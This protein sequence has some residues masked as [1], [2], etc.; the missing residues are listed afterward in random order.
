MRPREGGPFRA[1]LTTFGRR[2]GRPHAVEL[3]AVLHGGRIYFS[4]RRPDSDWFRNAERNPRVL[5]DAPALRIGPGAEGTAAVVRDAGLA[6]AIS[7]LKYPG[8][9][10][11]AE[12]RVA[13]GVALRGA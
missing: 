11:A 2:T 12:A 7:R 4:R 10:R 13:V 1:V 6:A 5:V 8:Q 3:L 9:E